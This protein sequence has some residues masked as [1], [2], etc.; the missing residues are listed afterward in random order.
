MIVF[1]VDRFNNVGRFCSIPGDV[2]SRRWRVYRAVSGWRYMV[3][4][5]DT[6]RFRVVQHRAM[7]SVY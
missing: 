3:R 2:R 5:V 4:N 7:S 1:V 6:G